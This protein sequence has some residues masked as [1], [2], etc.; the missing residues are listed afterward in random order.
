M[1][2][3]TNGYHSVM[4]ERILRETL[5]SGSFGLVS[6]A[7]TRRM[8]A[9]RSAGNKSTELRLRML[10]VRSGISGWRLRPTGYPGN[11]D[12]VFPD[13]RV[14][15]FVDGCFWHGC[16]QCTHG[17]RV[18]KEYWQLKISRN[19]QR[20]ERWNQQLESN[21]FEVMRIWEHELTGGGQSWLRRLRS[22]L[23]PTEPNSAKAV[24][25]LCVYPMPLND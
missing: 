22:I 1:R 15:L 25:D 14:A 11:P 3:P 24:D 10:F 7:Q 2:R 19:R 8:S 20:D 16:A 12:F 21:G 18:N 4:M 9:I 6:E 13:S 5:Q 23:S 17:V